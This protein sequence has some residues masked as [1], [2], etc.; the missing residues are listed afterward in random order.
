MIACFKWKCSKM[1]ISP[2][3]GWKN[4]LLMLLYKMS[5]LS[6]RTDVYRKPFVCASNAP[7]IRF[8]TMFGRMY[9][10]FNFGLP[11]LVERMSVSCFTRS[12][13]SRSSASR[14]RNRFWT[15]LI[16]R[17]A[18][19]KFDDAADSSPDSLIFVLRYVLWNFLSEIKVWLEWDSI[20]MRSKVI[21]TLL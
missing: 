13:F 2:S 17:N 8:V 3:Q 19:F 6:P 4:A 9:K 21:H 12:S 20:A 10:S 18:V 14:V 11:L 1:I 5:T 7:V 15:S 16:K